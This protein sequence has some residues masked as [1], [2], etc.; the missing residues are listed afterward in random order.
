MVVK[1][2]EFPGIPG[3]CEMES[4]NPGIYEIWKS[5]KNNIVGVQGFFTIYIVNKLYNKKLQKNC[6][7]TIFM[8]QT[9]SQGKNSKFTM[10]LWHL[11]TTL[12]C[13]QNYKKD[14]RCATFLCYQTI[15]IVAQLAKD[16]CKLSLQKTF[17]NWQ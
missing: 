9:S 16:V 5:R 15:K 1:I 8:S 11:F 6:N 14:C 12:S 7:F 4:W 17:V 2:P 13:K 3:F 10:T